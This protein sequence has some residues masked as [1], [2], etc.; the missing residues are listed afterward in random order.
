MQITNWFDRRK[1][2]FFGLLFIVLISLFDQVP[3]FS[4]FIYREI[5][6]NKARDYV[7][8][9]E[10]LP[11]DEDVLFIG[12]P[13]EEAPFTNAVATYY[14]SQYFLAPRLVVLMENREQIFSA[15]RFNYFISND[16]DEE[17]LSKISETYNLSKVADCRSLILLHKLN[18]Q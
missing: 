6:L 14:R 3:S 15:D 11:F 16:L 2:A 8:L 9:G 10:N 17:Q 13:L 1:I 18:Q 5:N 12:N 4:D 7:C